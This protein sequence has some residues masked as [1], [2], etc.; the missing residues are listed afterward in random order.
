MFHNT[1]WLEHDR[2]ANAHEEPVTQIRAQLFTMQA[3]LETL[4]TRLDQVADLRDAQGLREGQR[5]LTTRIAEVE[6]CIS[7]QNLREFMRRIMRL[8]AQVGGNHGGVLGEA[9][10][11]CHLRLDGHNVAMQEFQVRIRARDWYHDLSEQESDEEIRQIVS[12]AE[13]QETNAENQP[14]MENRPLGR[15]RVRNNASQRRTQRVSPRT[16]HVLH[17]LNEMGE[18]TVTDDCI[19]HELARHC[20]FYNSQ[21]DRSSRSSR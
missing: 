5:T 19:Q 15:R 17:A 4:R 11:A 7:V 1:I 13:G 9:I 20:M 2:E 12:R 6:D 16:P 18:T 10:R 3:N 8:E 21:C 14:G